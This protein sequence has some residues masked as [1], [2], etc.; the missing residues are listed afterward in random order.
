VGINAIVHASL[1]PCAA[2]AKDWDAVD[3]HLGRAVQLAE[4][5]GYVDTDLADGFQ[6]C[7][8]ICRKSGQYARAKE[9]LERALEQWVAMRRRDRVAEVRR[10]L[11]AL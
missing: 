5:V 11:A 7:A 2:A 1:A 9:C 10:R 3:F 4:S 8:L 6:R